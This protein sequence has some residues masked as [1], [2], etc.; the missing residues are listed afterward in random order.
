MSWIVQDTQAAEPVK[1][2]NAK[3]KKGSFAAAN[4]TDTPDLTANSE[5]HASTEKAAKE[6]E[7]KEPSKSQRKRARHQG[8]TANMTED[9]KNWNQISL[10]SVPAMPPSPEL[11]PF[12]GSKKAANSKPNANANTKPAAKKQANTKNNKKGGK[13]G[14]KGQIVAADYGKID[15]WGW[16]PV[17]TEGIIMDDMDG[18]LCLEELDDV[19]V[20]YEGTEAT[21]R[22]VI[23]KV[24]TKD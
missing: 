18:F 11:T 23:F 24:R 19:E 4:T 22:T 2:S 21:G 16:T 20:A 6:E 14:D 5:D 12:T 13:K 17:Q 9:E 8:S 3:R 7:K 1:R 10:M 15:D